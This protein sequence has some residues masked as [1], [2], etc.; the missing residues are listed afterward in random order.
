MKKLIPIIK[1]KPMIKMKPVNS[2]FKLKP[3]PVKKVIK[4]M[5]SFKAKP[6]AKKVIHSN[7][8]ALRPMKIKPHYK[9]TVAEKKL[10]KAKPWGDRDGD[11]VPNWIDCKPFNRKR[12][13]LSKRDLDNKRKDIKFYEKYKDGKP[14]EKKDL[15]LAD[16]KS[17]DD[18]EYAVDKYAGYKAAKE[19]EE[20]AEM[21][22]DKSLNEKM[23]EY[24]N[25]LLKQNRESEDYEKSSKGG[26][27]K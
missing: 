17:D 26:Q 8:F 25:K 9:R 21:D 16:F 11:G 18:D 4:P 3:R 10:I 14:I 19:A 24:Y 2:M 7:P 13:G 20:E 6:V 23:K 22:D 15:E 1:K 27:D 5:F 12:Q